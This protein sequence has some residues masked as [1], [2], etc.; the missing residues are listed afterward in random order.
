MQ[1]MRLL[2]PLGLLL[3]GCV[4]SS[5]FAATQSQVNQ[6]TQKVSTLETTVQHLQE[7]VKGQRVVRL[8]TGA[9]MRTIQRSQHQALNNAEEN[10]YQSATQLYNSGDMAAAINA[11]E[12]FNSTYPD[13]PR[14]A[15]ALFYLGQAYYA[16]RR[17]NEA[18][19]PLESLI[20]QMPSQQVNTKALTLL[21]RLYQLR[22][23]REKLAELNSFIQRH[24]TG[25]YSQ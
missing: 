2:L 24:T 23:N 6:L 21:K 11:F 10:S 4:S 14:R 19:L 16:Q 15:D 13:S 3:G 9:P 22:G 25:A 18:I 5:D 12:Q 1:H 20:Y 17:Y 8:P 7:A